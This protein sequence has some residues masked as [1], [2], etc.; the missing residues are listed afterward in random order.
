MEEWAENLAHLVEYLP[1]MS[2]FPSQTPHKSTQEDE[3]FKI[4]LGYIA[5]LRLAWDT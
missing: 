2:W 1:S 4:T 3:K 5:N